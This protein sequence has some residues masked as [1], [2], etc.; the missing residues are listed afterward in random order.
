MKEWKVTTM[1]AVTQKNFTPRKEF[2][3]I[4]GELV[5]VLEQYEYCFDV[6][7]KTDRNYEL[8]TDHAYRTKSFRPRRMQ[9]VLFV[10]ATI[11]KSYVGIYF[12]PLH[13]SADLKDEIPVFFRSTLV[14]RST[15]HITK[16]PETF[17]LDFQKMLD[18]GLNLYR[19]KKW[20]R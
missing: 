9:G 7:N 3:D 6:R 1:P 15:F 16:M 14:G 17:L 20:I 12:Y 19:S 11:L 8:W 4:F 10:G 5:K 13:I 2:I 18:V